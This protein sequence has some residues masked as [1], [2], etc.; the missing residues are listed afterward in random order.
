MKRTTILIKFTEKWEGPHHKP[1]WWIINQCG[2]NLQLK[3]SI[4]FPC[5]RQSTSGAL[6]GTE[7]LHF[8][9]ILHFLF[10]K[11]TCYNLYYL[12][13]LEST[14]KKKKPIWIYPLDYL[15]KSRSNCGRILSKWVASILLAPSASAMV[16]ARCTASANQGKWFCQKCRN[17]KM[18]T[19]L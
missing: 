14:Q 4:L 3:F 9:L 19:Q 1:C 2:L 8:T 13:R 15:K 17:I 12:N 10:Y 18:R 6:F 16:A 11:V 5:N 7:E